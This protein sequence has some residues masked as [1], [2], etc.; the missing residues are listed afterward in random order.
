MTAGITVL[1]IASSLTCIAPTTAFTIGPAAAI[2]SRKVLA[3]RMLSRIVR[4]AASSKPRLSAV[5]VAFDFSITSL[6]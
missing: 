5:A 1:W 2:P 6:R 3:F 4:A